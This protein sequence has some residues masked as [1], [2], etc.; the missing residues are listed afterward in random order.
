MFD[1][2]DPRQNFPSLERGI[3]K[4]WREENTFKR[5][6]HQRS[7]QEGD[8]LDGK[9]GAREDCFSFYDGPPFATGLPH[10]GHLLAGTIKDVIPRYQTMRGKRVDRRFGWDCHGLPIENIIEKEHGIKSKK[11]IEAMGVKAFNDLCRSAVQR[12]TKEWRVVVERMGRWVD[13]DHDYRTMD[14]EYMESIWWVFASLA[15]KELIYEGRKP[16]HICPRCQTSLS[17]FEVTQGYREITDY[18]VTAKFELIDEPGTFVLAWTTTPWTLPGNLFLALNPNIQYVKFKYKNEFCIVAE[19]IWNNREN[20]KN[21]L[22]SLMYAK[23]HE[24]G[25]PIFDTEKIVG[26]PF[27]GKE[28]LEKKYGPLFPYFAEEYQRSAFRIVPGEFVTIDEGTGVVHIAPGF[29]EDD[30]NIGKRERVPLLQHVHMDGTFTSDVRE[31]SGMHVKPKEDP[32]K[33]DHKIAAWLDA[34]GK[35]FAAENYSHTYPHCWR[36]DTPLLNYATSSWFVSV[37]KIKENMLQ[38]NA[39]T[40]W[41]PSHIRDGRFGKW[42]ENARD[43]AISR[44]RYWGTPLPIW[45]CSETGETEVIGSRDDLM[46]RKPIRFT[47]VTVLRHGESGGNVAPLYQGKPPGT[48]LTAKGKNQ[49]RATADRLSDETIAR[50]YCSPLA[51][52]TQTAAI[53]AEE[54]DAEAVTDERLREVEFGEYE[55]TSIDFS[56]LTLVRARRAHKLETGKMESIYHFPG[57]ETWK[58]VHARMSDFLTDVLP[59]HRGEHIV[60]VTHADPLQNIRTFFTGEDPVKISHQPYP[61]FAEP[62]TFYWDHDTGKELDLHR[63]TVDTIRWP[64]SPNEKSVEVTI[65]RHGETDWN[66][67][68][69]VQGGDVDEPLNGEGGSQAHALAKKLAKKTFDVILSSDLKRTAGTAAILSKELGVPLA[70][71]WRELRERFTGEWSGTSI[72]DVMKKHPRIHEKQSPVSQHATPPGGESLSEFLQRMERA[73]DR[74]LEEF[75]GKKILIVT[76][77]GVIQGLAALAENLTHKQAIDHA[78][79]N[80]ELQTLTLHPLLRRIPEVLDCWFESGSMPYAQGHFPFALRT[81]YF[82]IDQEQKGELRI[83]S[84]ELPPGFP[85]DFIAEGID[86]TRGWF[87]TLTVLSAALFNLPAFRHC[88]VNGTVLAEDGRKMS[89]RLK[90]YPEPLEVVEKHGA[91]AVRFALM[92]SPAVRG[93]DLRFSEKLVLETVRSVLLPLWNTY[94]FFVTYANAAT[95]EASETRR[96]STHPL[97][98]WI[99]AE[100]QDLVNRMTEQLDGYD[101]SATCAELHDTID[102]LTNWYIR[103]SRRRF[104]GK[105]GIHTETAFDDHGE[106]RH[107]ALHTLFDV[108]LTLCQLLSPFCPFIT[109]AIY[110]NLVPEEHGSI[111]L[112]D[113]PAPRALTK[114]E[115]IL[116]SRT[117]LLRMIVTLGLSVRAERKVKLRQPL[118]KATAAIPQSLREGGD[119]TLDELR[120]LQEELNVKAIE[121]VDDPGSLAQAIAQVD[122]RKV[123]PRLG[124]RVQEII[125]AGKSGD[126]TVKENGEVLILE[127]VLSPEE[128]TIVYRGREGENIAA[129][130][131]IVVSMETAVTPALKKEG[132]LRD[133]LRAIQKLRKEEG[134]AVTDRVTLSIEGADDLIQHN[135]EV[136]ERETNVVVDGNKDGEHHVIQLDDDHSVT[137]TIK[138]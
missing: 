48:D 96:H 19:A 133:L 126:F 8:P 116:L 30:C 18:S 2:V 65:V 75:S 66:K 79:E 21:V 31:F 108:L 34:H 46:K 89:K 47:K 28:L 115:E 12:H 41:V 98:I 99:R 67:E 69:K 37:E 103:L 42:L 24:P 54:T 59:R 77:K 35:L 122:A 5:S 26:N 131:G 83:A 62:F 97:D 7:R 22:H 11:E 124:G 61:G 73:Y 129:D 57:M 84:G 51:R 135:K 86:Q 109:E 64:G 87:Y 105:S 20:P 74:L 32:S 13:M 50:I 56:D 68:R 72:D 110:L 112:T 90:N 93:E 76:H 3:L 138:K 107:A 70:G 125:I 58:H 43:W 134:F 49:V 1:P 53:I 114:E 92:S 55:G 123:G 136:I 91:D 25:M 36:C 14:P 15:E 78:K 132:M 106:D 45:R 6:I 88:I 120:L 117:R 104:A 118:S 128:V 81:S 44:S 52:T 119:L 101:L 102:A 80:A 100:V 130:R 38:A 111:H 137:I 82:A 95:W 10:Y 4:E 39:E 23:A 9:K 29:G 60:I 17:N 113:W 63:E 27:S 16:M 33:T 127:E 71:E 94:S 40:E 121:V 85:A